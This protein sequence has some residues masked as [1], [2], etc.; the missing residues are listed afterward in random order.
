MELAIASD[1]T[2]TDLLF[3]V[4]DFQVK[5]K[6]SVETFYNT[7]GLKAGKTFIQQQRI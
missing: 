2:L 5:A 6:L 7:N 3:E 4:L 1:Q